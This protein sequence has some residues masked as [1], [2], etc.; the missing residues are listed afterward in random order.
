MEFYKGKNI[1]AMHFQ[2]FLSEQ[3][4][5]ILAEF[6]P[7]YLVQLLYPVYAHVTKSLI[8]TRTEV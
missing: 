1:Y 5:Q 8:K 2:L 3:I 6:F 4:I 7:F